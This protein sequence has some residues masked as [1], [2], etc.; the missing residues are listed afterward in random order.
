MEFKKNIFIVENCPYYGARI[1]YWKA[2]TRLMNAKNITNFRRKRISG[3]REPVFFLTGWTKKKNAR[4]YN[5]AERKLFCGKSKGRFWRSTMTPG[6]RREPS[7]G[8]RRRLSTVV[9]RLRGCDHALAARYHSPG[10]P[11]RTRGTH[12]NVLRCASRAGP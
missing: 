3:P 6:S 2:L 11:C 10:Y 5:L 4:F 9:S 1:R 7:S 12:P 8:V